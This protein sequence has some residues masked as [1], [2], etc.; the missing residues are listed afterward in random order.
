MLIA[1][2]NVSAL[3][4]EKIVN[5]PQ[6]LLFDGLLTKLPELQETNG[7]NLLDCLVEI[8]HDTQASPMIYLS[9]M[10]TVSCNQYWLWATVK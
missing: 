6:Y 10:W 1:R 4:A 2:F 7:C 5:Q 8:K 3:Q 9:S